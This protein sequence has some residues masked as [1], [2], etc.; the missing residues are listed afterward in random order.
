MIPPL[1]FV[2]FSFTGRVESKVLLFVLG[3][4]IFFAGFLLR[5]WAQMHLHYRLPI[6]KA[7]TA[8]G[9]YRLTRNPIY[10]GNGIILLGLCVLSGLLW[11]LP[12]MLVYSMIVYSLVVRYEESHLINKYGAPY[13]AYLSAVPRWMPRPGRRESLRERE[14]APDVMKY[15]LPS[16]KA[17][18]HN[19]LYV[20]PFVAKQIFF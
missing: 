4:A 5:I 6:K 18:M 2:L 9:P 1:L 16:V 8:T 7:L 12:I 14:P 15:L 13:E 20:I 19:F 11:F 17:E 10:I 3:L